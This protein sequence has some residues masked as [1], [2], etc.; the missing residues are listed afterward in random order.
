[1]DKETRSAI[2]RATQKA[3]RILETDF[4]EQLEGTFEVLLSGV[5]APRGGRISRPA[6][7]R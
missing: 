6:S 7:T 2:E 1:M 5:V 3:R 4:A